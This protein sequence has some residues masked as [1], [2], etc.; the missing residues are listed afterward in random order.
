MPDDRSGIRRARGITAALGAGVAVAAAFWLGRATAPRD[1]PPDVDLRTCA[2]GPWGT[3]RYAPTVIEIPPSRIRIPPRVRDHE[4]WFLRVGTP[5]LLTD[6]LG[7]CGMSAAQQ[8]ALLGTARFEASTASAVLRPTDDFVLSLPP[9]V[10]LNLYQRLGREEANPAHMWPMRF[11]TRAPLGWFEESD[12]PADL[13]QTIDRLVYHRGPIALF[14]DSDLV[15]R[16]HG[17]PSTLT[18]IVRVFSREATMI[19]FLELRPDSPTDPLVD[20]WGFP[21]RK[22]TVRTLLMAT[23]RSKGVRRIPITMLLPRFA[24]DRL[25]R[26]PRREDP[27]FPNCHYTSVNFFNVVPNNQYTNL[28]TVARVILNEYTEVTNDFRLGD[29]VLFLDREGNAIHSCNYIAD[30]MVFSKNG[31]SFAHPWILT[32]LDDLVAFYSVPDPVRLRFVRRR[33]LI[34]AAA[35]DEYGDDP[36]GSE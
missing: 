17:T 12:L 10:R 21:N 3:L 25:H 24:R 20:Y 14:A 33:D 2:P 27:P 26:Y 11:D 34:S 13:L 35:E 1:A 9:P 15:I 8:E 4:E 36:L 23:Q 7:A 32:L 5:E 28:D 18:N 30:G 6:V 16:R 31:G 19:T 29:V 22:D